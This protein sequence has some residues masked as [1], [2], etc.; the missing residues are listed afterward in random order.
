MKLAI[1]VCFFGLIA[2]SN[3]SAQSTEIGKDVELVPPSNE[4]RYGIDFSIV[5]WNTVDTDILSQ[6]DLSLYEENRGNS[7]D[8]EIQ[9]NQFN[10]TLKLYSKIKTL[11]NESNSKIY[12]DYFHKS[13]VKE[14]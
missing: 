14:R 10:L 2:I 3:S 1:L 7:E 6:I 13:F 12:M 4:A 5:E 9:L 11:E 8:I